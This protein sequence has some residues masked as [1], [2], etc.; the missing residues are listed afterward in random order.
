MSL[1]QY[2]LNYKIVLNSRGLFWIFKSER[3]ID[4]AFLFLTDRVG[5]KLNRC[6]VNWFFTESWQKTPRISHSWYRVLIQ[7]QS[8]RMWNVFGGKILHRDSKNMNDTAY[9]RAFRYIGQYLVHVC[10]M[11]AVFFISFTIWSFG[12]L[13]KRLYSRVFHAPLSFSLSS[14]LSL[15]LPCP[16]RPE[17]C[18][19]EFLHE[20]KRRPGRLYELFQFTSANGESF[21]LFWSPF[22]PSF[23][24]LSSSFSLLHLRICSH[25]PYRGNSTF[26]FVFRRR[27]WQSRKDRQDER[28]GGREKF[29]KA[30]ERDMCIFAIPINMKLTSSKHS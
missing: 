11:S 18:S 25:E 17:S 24:S 28:N 20:C 16:L 1:H 5:I 14:F 7:R 27:H 21:L 10:R 19:C 26:V 6:A 22:S 9:I 29:R 2:I 30:N 12:A 4:S 13:F 15:S 23:L 3:K 8:G